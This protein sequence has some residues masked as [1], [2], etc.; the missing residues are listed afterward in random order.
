MIRLI[1]MLCLA[2][3]LGACAT[4]P[5][6]ATS[7]QVIRYGGRMVR[8]DTLS[9]EQAYTGG[10]TGN[11]LVVD[12]HDARTGR[13]IHSAGLTFP[14]KTPLRVAVDDVGGATAVAVGTVTAASIVR[15]A[16]IKLATSSASGS[17]SSA[18]AAAVAVAKSH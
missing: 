1:T 13:R 18:S 3:T 5:H 7:S 10:D 2:T 12:M 17:I 11:A 6:V 9:V 15:P 14:G 16:A 8:V 4:Q